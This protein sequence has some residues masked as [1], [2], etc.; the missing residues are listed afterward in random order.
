MPKPERSGLSSHDWGQ[1]TELDLRC[2]LLYCI[3]LLLIR[4][5][6]QISPSFH[7]K[8]DKSGSHN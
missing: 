8:W 3:V 2:G 4:L 6:T 7:F 1:R 5:A